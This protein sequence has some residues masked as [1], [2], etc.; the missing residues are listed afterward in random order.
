MNLTSILKLSMSQLPLPTIHILDK[1]QV[2]KTLINMIR[3]V[4]IL[5][6]PQGVVIMFAFSSFTL[7]ENA[8]KLVRQVSALTNVFE[9]HKKSLQL[10]SNEKHF[11]QNFVW[12]LFVENTFVDTILGSLANINIRLD[13]DFMMAS[14]KK[15]ILQ[16]QM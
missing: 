7:Y 11:H 3:K 13:S 4:H 5:P 14:Y 8:F 9:I 2:N 12:L 6:F 10:D 15:D 16:N 1:E